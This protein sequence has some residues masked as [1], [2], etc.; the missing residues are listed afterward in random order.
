MSPTSLPRAL[1]CKLSSNHIGLFL[2][3]ECAVFKPATG[4]VHVRFPLLG[5][6]LV[7]AAPPQHGLNTYSHFRCQLKCCILE[8]A[9]CDYLDLVSSLFFDILSRHHL[10]PFTTQT[11]H[12][13]DMFP[14]VTIWL[15]PVFS[16]WTLSFL[17]AGAISILLTII[18]PTPSTVPRTL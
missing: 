15:Q 17:R 4:A 6:L 13:K 7:A 10:L 2:F 9:F 5:R 14:F 1:S 12:C 18:F 8:E 11:T 16:L 3:S